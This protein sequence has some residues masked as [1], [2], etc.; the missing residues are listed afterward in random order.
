MTTVSTTGISGHTTYQVGVAFDPG[1]TRDVYALYGDEN[2][3]LVIPPVRQRFFVMA[4]AV[5]AA[6]PDSDLACAVRCAQA[7]QVATPFG[8][9]VGP[10]NAAFYA[11][12]PETEFDSFLTIGMDGP[13]LDP[14][15]LS[16]IG[17][18][19]NAWTLDADIRSADG[20]VFF[21]DR[22]SFTPTSL[23][24]LADE[25]FAVVSGVSSQ[26]STARR[27]SRWCS[28][29]SPSPPGL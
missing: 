17:I 7:Y 18:D 9:N 19:F 14:G 12:S 21:M 2:H 22:R 1:V 10:P 29:S 23:P 20:A 4:V 13:A 8:S 16:S 27:K 24:A 3:P 11:I 26:R 6:R 25:I 28:R 5:M 15:A